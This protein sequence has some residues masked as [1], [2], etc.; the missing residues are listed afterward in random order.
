MKQVLI[1]KSPVAPFASFVY[2]VQAKGIVLERQATPGHGGYMRKCHCYGCFTD[3]PLEITG[4]VGG[5]GGGG[6]GGGVRDFP[7]TIPASEGGGGEG[8]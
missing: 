6:G 4:K 5:G 1:S 7:K 8:G 2:T 3:G